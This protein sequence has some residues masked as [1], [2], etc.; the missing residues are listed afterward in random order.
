MR[1]V[2]ITTLLVSILLTGGCKAPNSN[3]EA[4]QAAITAANEW[5]LLAD[6]GDYS[7]SWDEAAAF[8]K[9]AV[10]QDKWVEM[11]KG[12][13]N[14]LGA[15]K[16][17]QVQSSRYQTSVPGAPDGEYVIIQFQTSFE[18]KE[19]AVETV[20]PMRDKDGT[21]RVSGYYIK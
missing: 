4:E 18:N 20:T 8:F 12:V 14:P 21:W 17:R 9:G 19:S 7:K 13:R 15:M 16:T 11:A 3:P 10:T 2:V 1:H 5:L 6:V